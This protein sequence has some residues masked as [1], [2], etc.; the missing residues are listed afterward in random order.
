MNKDVVW[1]IIS[2]IILIGIVVV[3]SAQEGFD[4]WKFL[5]SLALSSVFL[6]PVLW[7]VW[8]KN[9]QKRFFKD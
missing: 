6:V 5:P 2:S 9:T 4:N 7:I 8:D 1:K 3:I